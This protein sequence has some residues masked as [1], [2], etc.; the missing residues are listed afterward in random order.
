MPTSSAAIKLILNK[1]K[2]R[3]KNLHKC[4]SGNICENSYRAIKE[5]GQEKNDK[6][7]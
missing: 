3:Q 5:L 6:E 2:G 7:K 4:F 1:I